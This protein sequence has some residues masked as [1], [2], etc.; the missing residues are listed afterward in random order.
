MDN[1]QLTFNASFKNTCLTV[2]IENGLITKA[3]MSPNKDSFKHFCVTITGMD[4]SNAAYY[5]A[6]ISLE[7]SAAPKEKGITFVENHDE[8][9]ICNILIR[10][11][12]NDS[13]APN[14]G[15][16]ESS[17]LKNWQKTKDSEK[18][19]QISDAITKYFEGNSLFKLDTTL[20][21]V[22]N[23]TINLDLSSCIPKGQVQNTLVKLEKFTR[24]Y[25]NGVP[26][27]VLIEEFEDAN[28]KRK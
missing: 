20:V 13:G 17:T 7:N 18:Y 3:S 4:L 1:T 26:I 9:S 25:L 28:T 22:K 21:S 12:F 11:V 27:I 24:E 16:Y 10:K 2:N 19:K 14:S 15:R 8:L 5:G 6:K 23:N